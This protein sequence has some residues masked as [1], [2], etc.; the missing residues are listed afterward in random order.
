VLG[1]EAPR[2]VAERADGGGEP[3]AEPLRAIPADST[4]WMEGEG[5]ET[6]GLPDRPL[7]PVPAL[8][9][10]LHTGDA[11][12]C[13]GA[14]EE[15]VRHGGAALPALEEALHDDDPDVRV[16]VAKA[17]AAIRDNEG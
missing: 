10:A 14:V 1:P 3:D 16:D 8:I 11:L 6:E 13:A 2:I 4:E 9:D 15:L 7:R 17:I 5:L 12:V